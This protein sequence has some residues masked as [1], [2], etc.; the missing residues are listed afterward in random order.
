MNNFDFATS[1]AHAKFPNPVFTASGCAANGREL[2]A[3]FRLSD[4]GAVV[5][6]SVMSQPRSGRATP[7]MAE[8]PSGMLNA[9]G[10]QGPGIDTFL[11][12][13]LPWLAANGARTV[14]S[15]AGESVEEFASLA[16]KVRSAQGVSAIEVNISC[17]NVEN[18]GLVF[19][20]DRNSAREVIEAVKRSVGNTVPIIAKLSPDVTDIVSIAEEVMN[21][22]ADGLA[23][24]NTLLGMVIN[25]ET[26][27]P[28]LAN[29]TGGL[30]GPAIRPVA[31]RA[32]YQ[33]HRAMPDVPIV[34]MG[35]VITGNDAFELVLAGASAISVGTASFHDPSA[36][37]RIKGE[38][39]SLL[40]A[41][42]FKSFTEAV[43][44][45]HRGEL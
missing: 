25:T 42:G 9:I 43:G 35:G 38:L 15:I 19:A 34:G 32:I 30:S 8:T 1:L 5:T 33:V 7:R 36:A 27:R 39:E 3:F 26:M 37:L 20:C 10:L 2:S 29:K 13:D 28:T 45:A 14:V 41:R 16:R 4:I 12:E 11:K 31:V 40:V 21:A 24:I 22:G 44:F 17:P 6:K 18:R 23:M